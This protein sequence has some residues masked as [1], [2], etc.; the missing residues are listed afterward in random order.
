MCGVQSSPPKLD[1]YTLNT[2]VCFP[3]TMANSGF[4]V[5]TAAFPVKGAGKLDSLIVIVFLFSLVG[6]Q[7]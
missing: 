1:K 4:W 7:R 5:M 6:N 2:N 3:K